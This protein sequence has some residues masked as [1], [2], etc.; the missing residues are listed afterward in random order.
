MLQEEK[1]SILVF[2]LILMLALLLMGTALAHIMS[3]EWMMAENHTRAQQAFYLADAGIEKARAMIDDDVSI[4]L[5]PR[6]FKPEVQFDSGHTQ[7]EIEAPDSEGLVKIKSWA[8]LNQGARRKVE[9][10]LNLAGKVGILTHQLVVQYENPEECEIEFDIAGDIAASQ[11]IGDY[12]HSGRLYPGYV[13]PTIELDYFQQRASSGEVDWDIYKTSR[14]LTANDFVSH[15][16][17]FVEGD[18]HLDEQILGLPEGCLLVATGK[19]LVCPNSDTESGKAALNVICGGDLSIK[20]D[21]ECFLG[22]D[23]Y[24]HSNARLEVDGGGA[25]FPIRLNGVW[26]A[27]EILIRCPP[28]GLVFTEDTSYVKNQKYLRKLRESLVSYQEVVWIK[29]AGR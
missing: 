4:L 28:Q 17:I 11:I 16:F 5:S 24:L 25:A 10:Q 27:K 8:E 9:A 2:I 23:G 20:P 29:E 12:Q 3:A 13:F 26:E 15:A 19:V 14:R 7:V 21:G 6:D 1:G 22:L 18:V